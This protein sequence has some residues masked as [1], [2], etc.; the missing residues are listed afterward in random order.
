MHETDAFRQSCR[1][2]VIAVWWLPLTTHT[3]EFRRDGR[4]VMR[5][6]GQV[7]AWFVDQDLGETAEWCK[8]NGYARLGDAT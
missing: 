1:T 3:A 6:A 7:T 2:E 8:A 4:F 5:S